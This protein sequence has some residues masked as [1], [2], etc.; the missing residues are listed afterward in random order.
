MK[1]LTYLASEIQKIE[2][3]EGSFIGMDGGNIKSD[4]WFCGIEFGASLDEM[5]EYYSKA[6]KYNKVENLEIPYRD[7]YQ[8][9]FMKSDFD[10]KLALIYL[11]LFCK[12]VNHEKDEIERILKC[13]LY[14]KNSNIFKLNLFPLAKTDTGWN[15]AIETELHKSKDEYYGSLFENRVS[16]IKEL[17]ERFAPKTILCFSTKE[18]SEYFIDAFF[19]NKR[20]IN[21]I[22]DFIILEK[23]KKARIKILCDKNLKV[24]IIPFL[25]RGN[26]ASYDDVRKTI[27]YLKEN[28]L[29]STFYNRV[30][31]PA[32]NIEEACPVMDKYIWHFNHY[33]TP[34]GADL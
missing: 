25:G 3:S 17:V 11:N 9:R 5:E 34:A 21:Y 12:P 22:R 28:Y 8:G 16:F 14:N 20:S 29:W 10:R 27:N 1:T 18:H 2:N 7:D 33:L 31:G 32:V 23:G 24:I 26:L 13:E 15:T 30:E 19:E 6:V 4:L